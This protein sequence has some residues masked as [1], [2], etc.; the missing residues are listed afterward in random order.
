M[1]LGGGKTQNVTTTTQVPEYITNQHQQ[2]I[3][4]ANDI[5]ATPYPTYSNARLAGLSG[6]QTNAFDLLRG[7]VGQWNGALGNAMDT[8]GRVASS[9][10]ASVAAPAGAAGSVGGVAAPRQ[11]RTVTLGGRWEDLSQADRERIAR[12]FGYDG[13]FGTGGYARYMQARPELQA[14]ADRMAADGQWSFQEAAPTPAMEAASIGSAAGIDRAG[15]RDVTADRF[16][17]ADL[18]AYLNPY[19]GAVIDTTMAE[20]GR[21]NDRVQAATRARA[22]AAGAF[23][24]SRSALME[25]ENNRNFLDT[26]SR[27]AAQLNQQNF[28]QAQAAIAADQNR[29]LQAAGMNQTMDYNV[30]GQNA[31]AENARR[32]QNAQLAQAANAANLGAAQSMAQFDATQAM[33]AALANQ[34]M[35]QQASQFS[36]TQAMQAALA[37]QQAGLQSGALNLDAAKVMAALGQQKQ[38]LGLADASALMGIGGVQQQQD[39]AGLDLAYQD[40]LRQQ[41]YPIDMLNL[42]QGVL[43][44][45]QA[46]S[47]TTTPYFSNTG[48]NTLKG[49]L[50]GAQ[51]A[52]SLGLSSGWG[53]GLSGLGALAGLLQ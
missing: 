48:T 18:S 22:A 14:Q 9:P 46:G 45:V 13:D 12:G 15:V 11:T 16:T 10:V 6:D 47:S 23:G 27:A 24:G 33:Q 19:T 38:Q 8:A 53:A 17:D 29:A 40:F 20:L 34:Q 44:G 4:L 37:N 31:A 51:L 1:S 50:G 49:A 35:G 25:T 7:A 36:A 2:N 39:Q 41:Q 28:S 43:G 32:T 21:Q 42:R 5:A 3:G 26:A 52:N 30:A